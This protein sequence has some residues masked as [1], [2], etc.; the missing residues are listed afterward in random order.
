M[1]DTTDSLAQKLLVHGRFASYELLKGAVNAYSARI[2]YG[3]KIV[4]A[5]G[6]TRAEFARLVNLLFQQVP[7]APK[8]RE[9]FG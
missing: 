1:N 3:S 9:F 4:R 7:E 2:G 5:D 6:K 8:S